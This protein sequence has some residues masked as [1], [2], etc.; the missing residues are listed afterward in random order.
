MS[1]RVFISIGMANVRRYQSVKRKKHHLS[2]VFF[3]FTL[4][5]PGCLYQNQ[6]AFYLR[7]IAE[8]IVFVRD[9]VS[10]GHAVNLCVNLCKDYWWCDALRKC[11][12]N[13]QSFRCHVTCRIQR[14]EPSNGKCHLQ[15]VSSFQIM[16][17]Y[18]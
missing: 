16:S 6:A 5:Q 14:P 1:K 9:H 18:T 10:F 11:A 4:I 13:R 3:I 2:M 15:E 7:I 8:D 12:D 17:V